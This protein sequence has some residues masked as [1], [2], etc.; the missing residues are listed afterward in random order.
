LVESGRAHEPI[1]EWLSASR[2]G[3]AAARERL[4]EALYS[5]LRRSASRELRHFRGVETL[6]TTALVNEVYLRLLA[7]AQLPFESRS[8]LLGVAAIAMRR[9]LVDRARER[10]AAKRGGGARLETLGTE[11]EAA[12]GGVA[13]AAAEELL[14]L[15]AALAGLERLE[16][17][18]ARVVELRYFGG[19]TEEETASALGSSERTVRRDWTKARAFLHRQLARA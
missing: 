8:H 14:A 3:D 4:V 1:T 16:P 13:D 10:F 12:F 6:Q 15:E 2:G 5:E 11:A 17:R 18:L 7:G 9:L 19:M